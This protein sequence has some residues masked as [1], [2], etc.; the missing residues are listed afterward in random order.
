MGSCTI[1]C[2]RNA[3]EYLIV[4]GLYKSKL[5]NS[6]QLRIVMALYDQEVARNNGTLNYQQ[7]KTALKLHVDHDEKS[8]FRSPERCCGEVS[9]HQES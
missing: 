6:A 4:E 8:E 5:Q 3:L 9:S 1:N 2:E 7:L